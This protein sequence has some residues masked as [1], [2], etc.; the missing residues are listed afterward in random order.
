MVMH[1]PEPGWANLA[2]CGNFPCTG[3]KNTLFLFTDTKYKGITPIAEKNKE[4]L[5]YSR[6]QG[7]L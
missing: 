2:D 1:E 6:R 7:F 4:F 3:P 5:N